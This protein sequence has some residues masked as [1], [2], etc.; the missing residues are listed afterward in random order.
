MTGG[1][2]HQ[3]AQ[4]GLSLLLRDLVAVSQRGG[5][6]LERNGRLRRSLRWGGFLRRLGYLLGNCHEFPRWCG[7]GVP[8]IWS[9]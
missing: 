6:V 7:L 9:S 2:R 1:Q 4:H 5:D 8:L 3:I